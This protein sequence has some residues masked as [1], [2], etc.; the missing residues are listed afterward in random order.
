MGLPDFDLAAYDFELPEDRIA[1][2]PAVPRDASRLLVLDRASGAIAH[3]V[4]ADLPDLLT[5]GDLVVV[6]RSKVFPARL[7][8][9][10]R[11]SGGVAEALLVRAHGD[12]TWDALVW[13]GRRL[14]PG[15]VIEIAPELVVRVESESEGEEGNP[16]KGLRRVRLLGDGDPDALVERFG[17]VPLPPYIARPD[18]AADRERYQTLFARER[19]SVAAPTAGLHFTPAVMARLRERGIETAEVVLHVGPGTFRPVTVRDVREHK[20]AAEACTLPAETAAQVAACRARGG[21]VVAVGTTSVRT[22]ESHADQ[23]GGVSPG[24]GDTALVIVP[25][26]RFVVVDA[27]VTNFHLPRSSLLLLVAAFAGRERVLRAY[28][29]AVRDGYRF[30]SYGDAMLVR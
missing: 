15:A 10:K 20:V 16:N 5:P 30:Y 26:H 28:A 19:G 14:R 17:H 25:G 11:G 27:I 4:F 21:R 2:Q 9:R 29:T 23:A 13:P 18:T 22:L 3:H 1:Q 6:N 24:G 8:G 12:G 7:V